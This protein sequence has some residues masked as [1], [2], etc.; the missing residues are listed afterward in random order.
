MAEEKKEKWLNW[1]ALTTLIFSGAA[2]ISSF[3]GGGYSSKAMMS[4]NLASDQWAF[5][6]AKSI[7]QHSYDLERDL[8][9]LQVQHAPED[10]RPQYQDTID[11]Y[12]KEITRYGTEKKEI[13]DKAHGYEKTKV[14]AQRYG[15]I[16]GLAVLYLQVGIMLAALGAL[17]KKKLLW[18]FGL[19]PG[20]AGLVYFVNGFWL[21]F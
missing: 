3:K 12:T 2:T 17:L 10:V 19:V 21:F 9:R 18:I 7:K 13:E 11:R 20:I 1:L 14:E 15:G 4:Q 8:L 16:F 6:Q 5:Y